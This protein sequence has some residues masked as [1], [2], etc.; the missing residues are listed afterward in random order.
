MVSIIIPTYNEE[1]FIG[2]LVRL[3][4]RHFPEA[5]IIVSDG[6]SEDGTV[7]QVKEHAKVVYAER[8]RAAQ[9]NMG[10]SVSTGDI[11]WFLHAD[12]RPSG[13]SLDLILKTMEDG[14]ALGGGFRWGL[15]GSKWYY[16]PLTALAHTK[17]KLKRNLFGDM[18]IFVRRDVFFE[19]GMYPEIPI[20]EEVEFNRRLRKMGKTVIL[21]EVL[22][23]SDR[24]L[25]KEGPIRAFIK[26]D[27]IKIA[28]SLGVSPE[29]LKKYY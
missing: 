8:G 22:P 14:S 18:G 25:L 21:D 13:R 7:A 27:I 3:L 17:N 9:M 4:V 6:H 24:K 11:L 20:C 1:A 23:S 12:C 16:K 29:K 10:A 5:E 15:T 2:K 28:F 26:N 19:L